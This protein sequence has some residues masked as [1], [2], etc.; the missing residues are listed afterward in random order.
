[1]K[2]SRT[3]LLIGFVA[4]AIVGGTLERDDQCRYSPHGASNCSRR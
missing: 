4:A 2:R 3:L 1:M